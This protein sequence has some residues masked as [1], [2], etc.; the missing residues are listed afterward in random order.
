MTDRERIR[1]VVADLINEA[2][3]LEALD[4][5]TATA[6]AAGLRMAARLLADELD[7]MQRERVAITVEQP[8]R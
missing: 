5:R 8:W 4:D 1:G 6:K 3:N 2:R 7:R